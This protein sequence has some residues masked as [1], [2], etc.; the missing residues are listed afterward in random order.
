V[1]NAKDK[2]W[3]VWAE[4][5]KSDEE[6]AKELTEGVEPSRLHADSVRML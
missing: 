4:I 3:Y 1:T 6:L 5:N 2:A